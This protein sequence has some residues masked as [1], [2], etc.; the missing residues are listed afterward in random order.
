M[1]KKHH[2]GPYKTVGQAAL[3][4]NKN[5]HQEVGETF[6]MMQH[7]YAEEL[8]N[9]LKKHS[10]LSHYFIIVL[11]KKEALSIEMPV[12]NVLRQWFVAPRMTKPSARRLKMD[13]PLHD[14]DIWEVTNGN[15]RHLWTLP[16]PD[17]WDMILQNKDD[18]D[19][20]LVRWMIE[21]DKGELK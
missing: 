16:G 15:P 3:A 9:T 18:N 6:E 14:H 20:N 12:N 7:K 5:E 10:D 1:D 2:D 17:V 21:Y 19:P 4:L 8:Q 13:Y 11:R